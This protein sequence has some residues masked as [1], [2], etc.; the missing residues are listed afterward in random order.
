MAIYMVEVCSTPA[1][2]EIE[3]K[4]FGKWKQL[5]YGAK[6]IPQAST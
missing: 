1:E 6:K 5:Q 2:E 4:F 3:Q